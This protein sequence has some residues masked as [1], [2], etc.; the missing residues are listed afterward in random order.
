MNA[1]IAN[2]TRIVKNEVVLFAL[3]KYLTFGVSIG[4][5]LLFIEILG[6]FRFG[7]W[8]FVL[9]FLQYFS[10]SN[11]GQHFTVN[12]QMPK[13]FDRKEKNEVHFTAVIQL[14]ILTGVLVFLSLLVAY[15]FSPNL[16]SKYEFRSYYLLV[17]PLGLSQNINKVMANSVR[18]FGKLVLLGIY[19]LLNVL[20]FVPVIFFD[21]E[22]LIL[23]LILLWL[24]FSAVMNFVLGRSVPLKLHL[25]KLLKWSDYRDSLRQGFYLLILN[26][27]VML[28]ILSLRTYV[29][30]YF[31]VEDLG[32]FSLA[33]SL[34]VATVVLMQ[35]LTS[36]FFPK[37]MNK[38]SSEKKLEVV[39]DIQSR[40]SSIYIPLSFIF[41][42]V[43]ISIIPYV[44]LLIPSLS[45]VF[46]IYLVLVLS[47][48]FI[49]FSTGYDIL[50]YSKQKEK[51]VAIAGLSTLAITLVLILMFHLSGLKNLELLASIGFLSY[52]IYSL[53]LV[54]MVKKMVTIFDKTLIINWIKAIVLFAALLV[55]QHIYEME[56]LSPIFMFIYL[57]INYKTIIR[58]TKEVRIILQNPNYHRIV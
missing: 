42:L 41:T 48:T 51:N 49:S 12:L 6:D 56:H 32:R 57:I 17:I 1:T 27:C 36:A 10:Y 21:N 9:L 31:S 30:V 29:S 20:I 35:T 44:G 38:F 2:I 34:A 37:M 18:V 47:Y 19:E 50:L 13:Y 39:A 16:F 40:I 4:R 23:Q 43:S 26:V 7:L 5:T 54:L 15:S 53:I 8:S 55:L 28:I 33:G 3:L 58:L 14:T 25:F 22:G 24:G 52:N 45:K 46:S 11:V